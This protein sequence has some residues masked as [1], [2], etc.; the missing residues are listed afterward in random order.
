M[1]V[2]PVSDKLSWFE[3]LPLN[4]GEVSEQ[5]IAARLGCDEAETLGFVEPL[6]CAD[7]HVLNVLKKQMKRRLLPPRWGEHQDS[8]KRRGIS[9]GMRIQNQP[10]TALLEDRDEQYALGG[11]KFQEISVP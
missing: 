10:R 4:R 6:N 8:E 5:I 11:T 7:R 9:A 2:S 3:S 1:N